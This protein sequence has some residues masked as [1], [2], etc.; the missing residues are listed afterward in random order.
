MEIRATRTRVALGNDPGG[1]KTEP[2][3][4]LISTMAGS[5]EPDLA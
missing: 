2:T 1:K 3:E 5:L 4:V